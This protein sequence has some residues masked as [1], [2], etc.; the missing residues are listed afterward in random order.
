VPGWVED[1][2][3]T[4]LERTQGRAFAEG[5]GPDTRTLAGLVEALESEDRGTRALALEALGS[6]GAYDLIVAE[7]NREGDPELRRDAIAALRRIGGRDA[8]SAASL[9]QELVRFVSP[10]WAEQVELLL[11]GLPPERARTEATMKGL[12]ELLSHPDV[13]VRELAIDQLR[14]LTGRDA[15][16]YDADRPTGPGLKAWQDLLRAGELAPPDPEGAATREAVPPA[17]TSA[18]PGAARKA[19][20]AGREPNR[21][22]AR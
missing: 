3:P 11:F 2:T 17:P 12:V 16:D 4:A 9:R 7:L 22:P 5:F 18:E 14:T 6:V 13:S 8:A 1:P 10:T 21:G 20:P 19:A 15:L